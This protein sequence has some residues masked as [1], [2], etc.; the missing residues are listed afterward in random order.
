MRH[1]V[2]AALLVIG[3]A[4][5]SLAPAQVPAKAIQTAAPPASI[6]LSVSGAGLVRCGIIPD[7][8]CAYFIELESPDHVVHEGWFNDPLT[9]PPASS[10]G[11]GGDVPQALGRGTYQISF[12]KQRVSDLGSFIPVPGGT[13]RETNRSD[14]FASCATT[15]DVSGT[16]DLAVH[17]AFGKASCAI[18]TIER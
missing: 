5:C 8:G 13:P 15:L 9:D 17:V 3:L 18:S 14:V 12:L 10:T 2:A 6:R 7:W 16:S 11:L 4:G 1:A